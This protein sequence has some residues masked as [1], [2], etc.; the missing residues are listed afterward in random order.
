MWSFCMFL[1]N[2]DFFECKYSAT[3]FHWLSEHITQ[4]RRSIIDDIY[5]FSQKYHSNLVFKSKIVQQFE[6]LV[7]KHIDS[8]KSLGLKHQKM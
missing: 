5:Q 2:F 1:C 3:D 6:I 7:Q 8:R 4:I